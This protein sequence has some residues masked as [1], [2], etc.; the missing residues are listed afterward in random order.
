MNFSGSHRMAPACQYVVMFGRVLV[1]FA[2]FSVI[3]PYFRKISG[4]LTNEGT[5]PSVKKYRSD[6]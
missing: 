6:V 2:C 3:W 4:K 5:A 1:V